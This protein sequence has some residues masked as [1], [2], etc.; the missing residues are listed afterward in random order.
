M[1]INALIQLFSLIMH[2][3]EN[4]HVSVNKHNFSSKELSSRAASTHKQ[5]LRRQR[6]NCVIS[7][8]GAKTSLK[9]CFSFC[10]FFI[11]WHL[12]NFQ[13]RNLELIA[14]KQYSLLYGSKCGENCNYIY[15]FLFSFLRMLKLKSIVLFLAFYCEQFTLSSFK[16]TSILANYFLLSKETLFIPYA[17]LYKLFLFFKYV[18]RRLLSHLALAFL[19]SLACKE[20]ERTT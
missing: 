13:S 1:V 19:C 4:I 8:T 2:L 16:A 10:F 5:N 18:R 11:P 7:C 6:S 20:T 12:Y 3:H 9:S 15:I 17:L 14:A